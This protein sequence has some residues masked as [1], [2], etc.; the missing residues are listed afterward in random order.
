MNS[1]KYSADDLCKI[2]EAC[3][4]GNVSEFSHGLLKIKFGITPAS[5]IQVDQHLPGPVSTAIET[6]SK[7]DES[8]DQSEVEREEYLANLMVEDPV[9]Y[10]K[11][12]TS[13]EL[14]DERA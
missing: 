7:S 10:E 2:V 5:E 6:N 12:V 1:T 8:P 9:A 14:E 4:R 13:G 11:L 3:T